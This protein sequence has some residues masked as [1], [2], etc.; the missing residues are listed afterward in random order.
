MMAVPATVAIV[1]GHQHCRPGPVSNKNIPLHSPHPPRL[2]RSHNLFLGCG[3]CI[4]IHFANLATKLAS[5]GL[6]VLSTTITR[7]CL[8]VVSFV[9]YLY[10]MTK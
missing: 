10:I 2:N 7:H 3:M 6:L 8:V 5:P 1:E 4:L 9:V